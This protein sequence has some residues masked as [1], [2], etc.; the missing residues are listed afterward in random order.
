MCAR[1]SREFCACR[2]RWQLIECSVTLQRKRLLICLSL[3]YFFF[4]HSLQA[5]DGIEIQQNAVD[6]QFPDTITFELEA[7]SEGQIEKATLIYGT[8][9]LSCQS[10]GSLQPV[11]VEAA[12]DIVIDWEWELR[13]SGALPPGTEVW[14]QWE[15]ADSNGNEVTTA[16]QTLVL[17]D[18][19]H[20]WRELSR[21]GVTVYWYDGPLAFGEAMLEETVSSLQ[22][23]SE[24]MGV[25][26]PDTV[27]VWI[28]A[29]AEAVQEAVVNVPEWTGGVAFPEYG[30][31]VLGVGPTQLDWAAQIVPHELTHL[32][33]GV[34]TFNC[35]GIRLPTWLNEGLARY[36]EGPSSAGDLARLELALEQGRLPALRSLAGGF[37]AYSD[38]AN[39]AYT[40]SHEAVRFLIEQ[41][42]PEQMDLLLTTMQSGLDVDDA[43]TAVYNLDT[44]SLDAA[45]RT[46]QGFVP[47]PTIEIDEQAM[48]ATATLVPTLALGGVPVAQV[49]ATPTTTATPTP[50]PTTTVFTPTPTTVLATATATREAT[51]VPTTTPRPQPPPVEVDP[52]PDWTPLFIGMG[53]MMVALAVYLIVRKRN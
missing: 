48:A 4:I 46:A 8:D 13:R 24:E 3:F 32:V 31:T 27:Q 41:Y 43:L 9:S 47:T 21:D 40:Q 17:A 15:V 16:R 1:L 38:A 14:W 35:R 39:L 2:Q 10:G 42:G 52:P 33:I 28:Y 12:R 5:Q 36:A 45:W 49:T 29:S 50:V 20:D 26:L 30:I 11:D 7:S 19:S 51:A 6:V 23:I 18:D 44:N 22:R 53:V 37:S 25:V 34:R